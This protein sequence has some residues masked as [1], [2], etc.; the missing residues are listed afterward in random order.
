[1]NDRKTKRCI[2]KYITQNKAVIEE[3]RNKINVRP[4]ENKRW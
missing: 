4:I 2:R 3:Q 1:M